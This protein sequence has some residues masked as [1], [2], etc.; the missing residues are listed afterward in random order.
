MPRAGSRPGAGRP[1][2]HHLKA[3]KRCPPCER[4][5]RTESGGKWANTAT[6]FV[7]VDCQ[8]FGENDKY[9]ADQGLVGKPST[10]VQF[11]K[12]SNVHVQELAFFYT[13]NHR[14]AS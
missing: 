9:L 10:P 4:F 7:L 2:F 5:N 3:N 8:D 13:G 1:G 14:M 12:K 11:M 6:Y